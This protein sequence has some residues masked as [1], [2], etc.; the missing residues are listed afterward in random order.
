MSRLVDSRRL[1]RLVTDI[2]GDCLIAVS[3]DPQKLRRA[4]ESIH[5]TMCD[6]ALSYRIDFEGRWSFRKPQS[7]R[8][9]AGAAH[10]KEWRQTSLSALTD[11]VRQRAEYNSHVRNGRVSDAKGERVFVGCTDHRHSRRFT[12]AIDWEVYK[13]CGLMQHIVRTAKGE[14]IQWYKQP[15]WNSCTRTC[16]AILD[17]SQSNDRD[18]ATF[19]ARRIGEQNSGFDLIEGL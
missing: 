8:S 12:H 18:L 6:K 10:F 17:L 3:C 13:D 7:N 1:Q 15:Q 11:D 19:L 16:R 5:V 14:K 2:N 4:P 9:A